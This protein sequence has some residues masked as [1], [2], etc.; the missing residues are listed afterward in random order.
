MSYHH[1]KPRSRGGSD[2]CWNISNVKSKEHK[3]C[4]TMFANMMPH[5]IASKIN[6]VWLDPHYKFIVVKR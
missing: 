3:A 5:D 1:R 2:G 6:E 4:H